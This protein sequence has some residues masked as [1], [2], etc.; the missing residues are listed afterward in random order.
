MRFALPAVFV[1]AI[2]NGL[3]ADISYAVSAPIA[4]LPFSP[5]LAIIVVA[6]IRRLTAAGPPGESFGL[7]AAG[8]LTAGALVP[9]SLAS[10]LSLGAVS[11]AGIILDRDRTAAY[12]MALALALTQLWHASVFKVFAGSLTGVE[13]LLLAASLRVLGFDPIVDGNVIHVTSEHA[14]VL[15]SGCSVFSG[16]GVTL[17]GWS[18]V[19]CLMRPG[20]RFS[21][22]S[23]AAVA[24]AAIALNLTRLIVMAHGPQWHAL[25]HDGAGAQVYDAAICA[26][27]ISAAWLP[28]GASASAPSGPAQP[29]AAAVS[30][31]L[32]HLFMRREALACAALLV[33]LIVSLSMKSLRYSATDP[34]GWQEAKER[35]KGAIQERG[36]EFTGTV[37]MTADRAIE[38]MVFKKANCNAPLVIGMMGASSDTLPLITRYMDGTPIALYVEEQPVGRWA[39]SRFLAA[40]IAEIATSLPLGRKPALRPLL[41]VSRP[42]A[43]AN[44]DCIWPQT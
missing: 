44:R 36:F 6:L 43:N 25:V 8:L 9:S 15:L 32:R 31:G 7:A 39:V 42:P 17:L 29:K 28:R 10:W 38:G 27:V 37:S 11:A 5:V 16:L 12:R 2:V 22:T 19:F 14:L 1:L 4:R 35:I 26:L 33:L 34:T 30:A 20:D 24:L 41:A 3:L 13:A 23:V 40:N 21:A 18:A